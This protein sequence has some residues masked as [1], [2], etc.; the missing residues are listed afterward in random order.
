MGRR[1][2]LP[3]TMRR[4]ER[5]R[6]DKETAWESSTGWSTGSPRLSTAPSPRPSSPRSSPWRRLGHP[7][8]HGRPGR[9][10]RHGRAMVPNLYTIELSSTDF[11]RLGDYEDELDDLVAAAQEH[12]DSQGY[13]PGGPPRSS[14]SRVRAWRRA[15]SASGRRRRRG[16]APRH[17]RSSPHTGTRHLTAPPSTS[18][19]A[20]PGARQPLSPAG[21][22]INGDRYPLLGSL[23]TLG[24][25]SPS[26]SSSTTPKP[27]V[28]PARSGD[29]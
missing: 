21:L 12:A 28:L 3:V 6:E 16:P 4:P 8:G 18:N 27:S 7:T 29:D 10:P 24:R 14:S 15:S 5:R 19:S 11:E 9:T 26:T 25:T 22:D 23:T 13:Q 17:H 20:R 2:C 1:P